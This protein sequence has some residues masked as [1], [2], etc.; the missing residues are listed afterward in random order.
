[1]TF[2]VTPRGGALALFCA[3]GLTVIA[4]LAAAACGRSRWRKGTAAL[5]ARLEA[6][7]A[8][9]SALPYRERELDGLPA[10]VQRFF[11]A[12]LRDG[13]AF[14]AAASVTHTGSMNMSA[15][16]EQWRPFTSRQRVITKRP[17][18]DWDARIMMFPGV[19]ACV[20]DAYV[21]GEGLLQVAIFGLI[22]VANMGGTPE[23]ARGELLRFFAE[24]AWYP[25][26]LLPSQGVR[27]EAVSD[28]SARATLT[29]GTLAVT[30]LFRFNADG[31]IDTIR[32]ES[33]DRV[34]N[35]KTE[36]APWQGRFWNYAERGGMQ[37]PLD[38]EV[39]WV[40]AE[41]VKTYWRGTVTTLTFELA[42]GH[43]L[44]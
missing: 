39:A 2:P 25:T 12:A 27:W 17:G 34:V 9:P 29:D 42:N 3:A 32:A 19:P 5:H 37:V 24:A 23:L 1:V 43:R 16:A 38:G 44:M 21:A 13:Q 7:R 6:G 14:V 26:A 10:P 28:T 8:L 4:G 40:L 15:T 36:S 33:R 20:H 35:G 30:L 18:F 41:G 11:R 22:P 31:L